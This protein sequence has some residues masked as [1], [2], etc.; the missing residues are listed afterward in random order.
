MKPSILI[1]RKFSEE[2]YSLYQVSINRI[3]EENATVYRPRVKELE[4]ERKKM[5]NEQGCPAQE[6]LTELYRLRFQTILDN[7][8]DLN[9]KLE[10][11]NQRK[12]FYLGEIVFVRDTRLEDSPEFEFY[13]RKVANEQ[14]KTYKKDLDDLGKEY[15][16]KYKA[17]ADSEWESQIKDEYKEKIVTVKEALE[18]KNADDIR[19][20]VQENANHPIF[21]A[22]AERI[23]YDATGRKDPINDLD[24]IWEEY[25]KFTEDPGFFR[26]SPGWGKQI[27]LTY[28]GETIKNRIDACYYQPKFKKI[29]QTVENVQF[30]VLNLGTLISDISSGA[31]PKID[32]NYYTDSSGIP[33]LRVQNVTSEGINLSDIKFITPEV[34]NGNA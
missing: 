1:L 18:N 27:F 10:Q 4:N 8:E 34:H 20:W 21:M 25:R 31:T 6:A 26:V 2:E 15:K 17:A 16:E 19:Q 3:T 23:G 14:L 9:R 7:I 13:D 12:N 11:K 33:F 28:R 30:N 24:T 22:I 5:I 32:E 29:A